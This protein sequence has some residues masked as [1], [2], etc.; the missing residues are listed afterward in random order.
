MKKF[1][2]VLGI[3]LWATLITSLLSNLRLEAAGQ[4]QGQSQGQG[5]GRGAAKTPPG[6]SKKDE[7]PKGLSQKETLPSGLQKRQDIPEM[8]PKEELQQAWCL[9]RKGFV[10][11]VLQDGTFCGCLTEDHVV[12]FVEID[13]WTQA[14]G[15]V[16]HHALML[17]KDP[18][19]VVFIGNESEPEKTQTSSALAGL[20]NVLE[21]FKLPIIVWTLKLEPK[22]HESTNA[23][24]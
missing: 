16:L 7:L 8:K 20:N 15:L 22:L 2:Y 4:G 11:Y 9:E 19:I 21:E 3:V 13:E 5:Q 24:P 10:N 18:G 6:L 14:V 12:A 1:L 23:N 17:R